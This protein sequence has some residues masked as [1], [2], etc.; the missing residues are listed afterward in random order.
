MEHIRLIDTTR[1]IAA[2]MVLLSHVAFWTGASRTDLVGGLLARGDA[3]VAVFFALS[4]Y[5]LLSPWF[6][7]ALE[8]D[9]HSRP[10]SDY[11]V[12]RA[13]RILPAYWLALIFVIGAGY[14]GFATDSPGSKSNVLSHVFLTQALTGHHY[15][16]FSQTW[17]L[18]TEIVFYLL[19]PLFGVLVLRSVRGSLSQTWVNKTILTL[20]GISLIGPVTAGIARYLAGADHF[21]LGATLG[22]SVIGHAGWFAVGALVGLGKQAL[23]AGFELPL[24]RAR[25]VFRA[26]ANVLL[27]AIL[28]FLIASSPLAGPRDL[29][30]PTVTQAV[31]KELIYTVFAG[32]V[33]LAAVLPVPPGSQLSRFLSTGFNRWLGD[34]SYAIF[35]WHVLVLQ[36]VFALTGAE[37]FNARFGW[38]L[39][40]VVIITCGVASLSWFAVERPVLRAV[41]KRTLPARGR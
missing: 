33:L 31:V 21:Q 29:T 7:R 18:T 4:S 1:A 22:M 20:L 19:V 27:F 12:R 38:T 13:A 35:L 30:A 17:S 9:P 32:L 11:F 3:G 5:L 34:T 23:I 41:R 28:I 10:V 2:A 36:M 8:T 25:G 16:G 15:Q 14:V 6:A 24:A 39:Y 40:T 37:L 26:R